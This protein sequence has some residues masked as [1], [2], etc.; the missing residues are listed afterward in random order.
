M[1]HGIIKEPSRLLTTSEALRRLFSPL[2][3]NS[4]LCV[5]GSTL[6]WPAVGCPVIVLTQRTRGSVVDQMLP[7]RKHLV[8]APSWGLD[9]SIFS[10]ICEHFGVTPCLDLFAF[11]MHHVTDRFVSSHSVPGCLTVQALTQDW[12][13]LLENPSTDVAWAFPPAKHVSKSIS[14]I[15]QFGINIIMIVSSDEQS[16]IWIQLRQLATLRVSGPRY[17]L[18]VVDARHATAACG[19]QM[20]SLIQPSLSQGTVSL[21]YASSPRQV[22]SQFLVSTV[23]SDSYHLAYDL[24]LAAKP[25]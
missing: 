21:L 12:A 22:K 17:I 6:T 1:S 23:R 16:N 10:D 11:D 5:S 2:S 24:S 4:S 20:T 3:R 9:R 18:Q 19:F 13:Q 14:K 7:T 8:E 15:S 25:G